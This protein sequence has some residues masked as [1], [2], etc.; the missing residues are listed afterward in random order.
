[1]NSIKTFAE[2]L[3]TS[4]GSTSDFDK[5]LNV[6][7]GSASNS[8]QSFVG[9][10]SFLANQYSN[11]SSIQSLEKSTAKDL[12][13]AADASGSVPSFESEYYRENV[14]SAGSIVHCRST[15]NFLPANLPG[16]MIWRVLDGSKQIEIEPIDLSHISK[17]GVS[18]KTA[19]FR[20]IRLMLP[21][22]ILENCISV[23]YSPNKFKLVIDYIAK[24]WAFY[25][26]AIPL[27]E[28]VSDASNSMTGGSQ[29]FTAENAENWYRVE[30]NP[31]FDLKQPHLVYS[32]SPTTVIVGLKDGSIMK[33]FRD[34]PLSPC[35]WVTFPE[36]THTLSFSK[37][38]WGQSDKFP[39]QPNLSVRTVV[40]MASACNKE[41]LITI[42]INRKLRI[43]HV[44]SMKL[45]Y[46]KTL[47][48]STVENDNSQSILSQRS[49]ENTLIGPSPMHLLSVLDDSTTSF[50]FS[51][52]LPLGNGLFETWGAKLFTSV[53]TASQ[54]EEF[55]VNVTNFG[56]EYQISPD[57]LDSSSTWLVNTLHL[58]KGETFTHECPSFNL[59]I[60]WKSNTSSHFC[61][62]VLPR[63]TSVP[64]VWQT[65]A[66]YEDQDKEY[67]RK[68]HSPAAT[69]SEVYLKWLFGP[70]GYS[71]VT[72]ETALRIYG[73]HYALSE[74]LLAV[75]EEEDIQ[76]KNSENNIKLQL[77]K[78]VCLVVG[79]AI[80]F[81]QTNGDLSADCERY[82][83]AM[84]REWQKFDRLCT[85][86]ERLGN[87]VL[88]MVWDPLRS[89]F[90]IVKASFTSVTRPLLP[91]ELCYYNRSA[92]PSA[93]L[94]S[95]VTHVSQLSSA[96]P[97]SLESDLEEPF[98]LRVLQI[99]EAI[100][101]FRRSFSHAHYGGFVNE[102]IEDYSDPAR[103]STEERIRYMTENLI[104]ED[105]SRES[106]NTLAAAI[107]EASAGD[108]DFVY[109]VLQFLYKLG[110]LS[111][112]K[113]IDSKSN[114]S[115]LTTTGTLLLTQSL[116]EFTRTAKFVVTDVLISLLSFSLDSD[117]SG[118]I[119]KPYTQ[120]LNLFKSLNA[121]G[122]MFEILP[123]YKSE[124]LKQLMLG[125]DV[126]MTVLESNEV[127]SVPSDFSFLQKITYK[128][129]LEATGGLS[130]TSAN[131]PQL[132]AYLL[133][134]WNSV[135]SLTA[136]A[137][138][139]SELLNEQNDD[140][141]L[142]FAETYLCSGNQQN[143]FNAFIQAH[144]ELRGG[145][146]TKA[147]D[148][149]KQASVELASRD[150]SAEEKH[151]LSKLPKTLYNTPSSSSSPTQPASFGN[152]M[153]IFFNAAAQTVDFWGS[154][155]ILALQL[156][157]IACANLPQYN[158]SEGEN[159]NPE[160]LEIRKTVQT[161]L[162]EFAI[163]TT[164]LDEAYQAIVELDMLNNTKAEIMEK[165]TGNGANTPL[166]DTDALIA[167][168]VA[169]LTT[170]ATL[171]GHGLA[172]T[173]YPF[174]GLVNVL[175]EYLM[176]QARKSLAGAVK[177][178]SDAVEAARNG[179]I[180]N[181][182]PITTDVFIYYHMLYAWNVEHEDMRGAAVAFLLKI[183]HLKAIAIVEAAASS[184]K[185][186][187]QLKSGGGNHLGL[188]QENQSPLLVSYRDIIQ[189]YA[190]LVNTLSCLQS[191]DQWVVGEVL[192]IS[193]TSSGANNNSILFKQT[194]QSYNGDDDRDDAGAVLGNELK[195]ILSKQDGNNGGLYQQN[196]NLTVEQV[197]LKLDDIKKESKQFIQ[198][199]EQQLMSKVMAL[200]R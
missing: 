79:S 43:W 177:S 130:L 90:W 54:E 47:A 171:A 24:D 53:S 170:A 78:K 9:A 152:G 57:I 191:S 6:F 23:C 5:P 120:Y 168:Y 166:V 167:P 113:P 134:R 127:K 36:P 144:A 14:A 65:A 169:R 149:F 95:T 116:Y 105:M 112:D 175:T 91:L 100:Y 44:R 193:A 188:T 35:G 83:N 119:V 125:G 69:H 146:S 104:D 101:T 173:K 97:S 197:V 39:M 30:A 70:E 17:E 128:N 126:D 179:K 199:Q 194:A 117:D 190:I 51:S 187:Q 46:E 55:S 174:I 140:D 88:S 151:V 1:M 115:W 122:D 42:S 180:A 138:F 109:K 81:T 129:Q 49:S 31:P 111:F 148:L 158:K 60:M 71:P 156:A 52:Y 143:S 89:T 182:D 131:I 107:S 132:V 28:F 108:K 85:E 27:S 50:Y 72:I 164:S 62:T 195:T 133:S 86:L 59:S 172:L 20:A 92:T 110:T 178:A 38:L 18:S 10:Q 124:N 185:Y 11:N 2:T 94:T 8:E 74:T 99:V 153:S 12:I 61:K 186:L 163:K 93:Q 40:S 135:V 67:L 159:A 196:M 189:G 41:I 33:I 114:P 141:A 160:A 162:F 13:T 4:P 73:N 80:S 157:K 45:L 58:S 25:T 63:N 103:F 118:K 77:K 84:S 16:S 136:T 96:F 142:A 155:D 98:V 106:R 26:I 183:Q 176:A 75:Q 121:V 198:R 68:A 34:S 87:E 37:L 137:L 15:D 139:V 29:F 19:K 82:N 200:V 147:L 102:F 32:L 161:S 3:V 123:A 22:E 76:E 21:T 56:S 150:L 181:T 145:R 184:V 192:A 66:L 48:D 154:H 165:K 7:V 64:P